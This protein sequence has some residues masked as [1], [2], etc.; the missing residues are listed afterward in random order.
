MN[1]HN[2]LSSIYFSIFLNAES[3]ARKQG[4]TIGHGCDILTKD[5]GSEPY[6]ITIG[7]FV[8]VA[9]GVSFYTHGGGWILYLEDNTFDYFGKIIIKDRT[10]IGGHS[11]ILPGVVIGEDVIVAAGSVVTKSVPDGCIVGGNPAKII[12]ETDR[13][14]KHMK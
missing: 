11:I 6:L 9:T 1:I 7:N 12:G 13:Y 5:F 14:K 8:Q 2:K 10:Y 4:V 3:F